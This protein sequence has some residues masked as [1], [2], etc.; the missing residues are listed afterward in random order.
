MQ[1]DCVPVKLYLER[2]AAAGSALLA[3][4]FPHETHALTSSIE[5]SE[6]VLSCSSSFLNEFP[7]F[8]RL[9]RPQCSLVKSLLVSKRI[10]NPTYVREPSPGHRGLRLESAFSHAS[11]CEYG[12][13]PTTASCSAS[14]LSFLSNIL[15]SS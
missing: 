8:L 4:A 15:S 5:K 11:H 7:H 6:Q 1:C 3:L 13:T 14:P 10:P 12:Q 2:P 9:I